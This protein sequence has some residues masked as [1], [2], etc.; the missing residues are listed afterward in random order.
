MHTICI[1]DAIP[2]SPTSSMHNLCIMRKLWQSGY[3]VT[4]YDFK[5]NNFSENLRQQ[6]RQPLVNT[7]TCQNNTQTNRRRDCRRNRRMVWEEHS[8]STS[9]EYCPTISGNRMRRPLTTHRIGLGAFSPVVWCCQFLYWPSVRVRLGGTRR[10][11]AFG[12][13]TN[14]NNNK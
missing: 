13:K 6:L 11:C 9:V 3:C 12:G 1:C 8:L 2:R 5:E 7:S 14:I 4:T 10:A